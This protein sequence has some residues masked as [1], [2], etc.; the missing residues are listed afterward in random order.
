MHLQ[1]ASVRLMKEAAGAWPG[2][3]QMEQGVWAGSCQIDQAFWADAC[4]GDLV[5]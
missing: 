2:R 3:C 4:L 5:D 1:A